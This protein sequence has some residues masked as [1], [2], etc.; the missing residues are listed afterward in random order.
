VEVSPS[1]LSISHL[2]LGA[3]EALENSMEAISHAVSPFSL[4]FPYV[5]YIS[6]A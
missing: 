2:L 5:Y 1:I 6:P 3:R 4:R